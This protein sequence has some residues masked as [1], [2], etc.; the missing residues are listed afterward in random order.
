MKFNAKDHELLSFVSH[1]N[2]FYN[3]FISPFAMVLALESLI[4]SKDIFLYSAL[5]HHFSKI[6][7]GSVRNG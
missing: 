7:K 4:V 2:D 5:N 1:Y 3:S 6:E